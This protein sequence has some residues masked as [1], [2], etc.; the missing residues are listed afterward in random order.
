LIPRLVV[1]GK[2]RFD[3]PVTSIFR[4][5]KCGQCREKA[6]PWASEEGIC[7]VALALSA[8]QHGTWSSSVKIGGKSYC[9]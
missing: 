5:E 6:G 7:S 9:G 3:Q 2:A 1:T 8:L 4:L